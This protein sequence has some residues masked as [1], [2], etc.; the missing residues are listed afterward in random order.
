MMKLL[1]K[2]VANN[3]QPEKN[4]KIIRSEK[5]NRTDI[6]SKYTFMYLVRIQVSLYK[7]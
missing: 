3:S 2:Q 1:A 6:E 4:L 5:I 7:L